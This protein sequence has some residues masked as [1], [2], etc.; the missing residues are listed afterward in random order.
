MKYKE[1]VENLLRE[2]VKE[3][4][5]LYGIA[6]LIE[7]YGNSIN[8][9]LQ[10]TADLIPLSWQY[11]EITSAKVTLDNH[12]FISAKFKKSL[13][14][15]SSNIIVSGVKTGQID[16][17]YLKKKPIIDEG[18][19]L[20]EERL[21]INSISELLGRA[22][23]RTRAEDQLKVERMALKNKNIALREILS[24]MQEEKKEIG[25]TV[26]ANVDRIIIPIIHELENQTTPAGQAC[27]NLLKSSL[28]EIT[29]PFINTISRK[30]LR[31]TPVEIQISNMI[32]N[33]L[34]TKEISRI[35]HISP[36][37]VSS[38]RERIRKKLNIV[39]KSINLATY[40]RQISSD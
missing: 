15:Q 27:L 24:K 18:P 4:S 35:R 20:K 17:Y 33:G 14:K 6:G 28:E 9:I 2:R 22:C 1:N 40:L 23:E 29:S 26:M 12:S 30:M 8:D 11:P 38:H 39:N 37:T 34:S 31:L 21:L 16:V 32:K 7:Q 25:N 5:C 3:L 10:G 19:F 13:W 36:S